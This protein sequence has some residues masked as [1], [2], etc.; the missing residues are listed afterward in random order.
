MRCIPPLLTHMSLGEAMGWIE[1]LRK[2]EQQGKEIAQR[3]LG[4]AR[5]T[6]EDTERRIRR[7]MRIFPGQKKSNGIAALPP[8]VIKAEPDNAAADVEVLEKPKDAA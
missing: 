8:L 6:W 7:K 2:T 4:V 3:G 1:A 5:D